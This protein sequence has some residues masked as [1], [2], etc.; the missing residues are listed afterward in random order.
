MDDADNV[1]LRREI[2]EDVGGIFAEHHAA[3]AWGRVLVEVVSRD[4]GEPQ[5]AGIEVEDIVGDEALVDEVF[6]PERVADLLPVLAKATQA[7]CAIEDVELE[8]VRGG[9]FIRQRAG[10]FAW[11]PGLVHLPSPAFEAVWDEAEQRLRARQGALEDRF[12]LGLFEQYDID[13]ASE[14][15]VFSS[16]GERGVEGRA[17]LIGSYS[18]GSR[19]WAWGGSNTNL[20]ESV[21]RAS[22]AL[23]DGIAERDMWELSTPIFPVDEGTAWGLAALVCDRA[24]GEG[25][26]RGQDGDSRVFVMLRD[27]RAR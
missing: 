11:L 1:R 12:G 26:Y 24:G 9:T 10:G 17:T 20:P 21:R 15:I 7:L 8:R 23:V 2:L 25:V 27:L 5:V 18:L 14:R 13:I 19:T 22:A 4:D 6:A 3:Q 16:G